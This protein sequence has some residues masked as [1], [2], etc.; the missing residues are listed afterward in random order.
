MSVCLF[1]CMSVCL[2]VCLSYRESVCLS[3]C[4]SVCLSVCLSYRESVCLSVCLFVTECPMITVVQRV[5]FFCLCVCLLLGRSL[6]AVGVYVGDVAEENA[7]EDDKPLD[8]VALAKFL[9]KA[10]MVTNLYKCSCLL[11]VHW[12]NNML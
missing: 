2:S 4:M 9:S 6:F 1:V 10:A 12:Y 8:S 7:S 5:F 11:C 3:V